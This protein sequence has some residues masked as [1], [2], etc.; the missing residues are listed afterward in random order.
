MC[1]KLCQQD[2]NCDYWTFV[3]TSFA[4]PSYHRDCYLKTG[5]VSITNTYGTISGPKYCQDGM[6]KWYLINSLKRTLNFSTLGECCTSIKLD[7]I[8]MGD[9][10]QGERLGYYGKFDSTQDGR[11]VY[12][13]INGDNFLYFL[14]SQQVGASISL[15]F[16]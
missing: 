16:Q 1:Q 12:K 13:Q 5:S 15:P 2:Q 11:N 9:F 7:T 4:D 14:Q 10:Y 8:G 3:T 6:Q